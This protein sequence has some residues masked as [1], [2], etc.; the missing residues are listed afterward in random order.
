MYL[1]NDGAGVEV[2]NRRL[3]LSAQTPAPAGLALGAQPVAF[4][5]AIASSFQ[6]IGVGR[7][8]LG[9]GA[10]VQNKAPAAVALAA[11]SSGMRP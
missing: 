6:H 10:N 4:L 1:S 7:A 2:A 8:R 9:D 3:P 11:P 5:R